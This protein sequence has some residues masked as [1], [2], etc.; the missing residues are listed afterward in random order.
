VSDEMKES[1]APRWISAVVAWLC[2]EEARN[3]TGRVFDIRGD[4]LQIARA[5]TAVPSA[6]TPAIRPS[7]A[8]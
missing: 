6:R 8:R 7:S 4:R 2:S 1:M 3:V 5:G